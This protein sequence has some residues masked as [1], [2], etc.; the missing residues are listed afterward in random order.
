MNKTLNISFLVI[1]TVVLMSI[2]SH[3]WAADIPAG[4]TILIRTTK[5]ILSNDPP[6][7]LFDAVVV[8]E[9]AVGGK[10]V[11][12][13]GTP[14]RGVVKSPHFT[15]GSIS[16]PLTLKLVG[17]TSHGRLI[18]IDTEELEC[19]NNSPWTIGPNRR[20]QIVGD[21]FMYNAGTV[22]PFRLR[23]TVKV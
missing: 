2:Q 6:G 8:R 9:V 19:E 21:A 23:Q 16:R 20:V 12:P 1:I 13:A 22:I 11:I 7:H 3:G 18:E 5:N 15:V 4:T 10:V 14:V 17:I